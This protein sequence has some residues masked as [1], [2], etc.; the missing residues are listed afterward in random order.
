[1]L[2]RKP[3]FSSAVRGCSDD[4]SSVLD[5]PPAFLEAGNV[6]DLF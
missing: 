1:M 3:A 4:I 5:T 6:E 2:S